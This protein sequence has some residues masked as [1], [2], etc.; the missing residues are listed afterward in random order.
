LIK[1]G[2]FISADYKAYEDLFHLKHVGSVFRYV[3]FKPQNKDD[4]FFQ[5]FVCERYSL[6]PREKWDKFDLAVPNREACLPS[7]VKYNK[8]NYQVDEKFWSVAEI[9]C[10]KHFAAAGN[11]YELEQNDDVFKLMDLSTSAGYPFNLLPGVRNKRKLL[12][13]RDMVECIYNYNE[14]VRVS[15][16][17]AFWAV[18]EKEEIRANKKL[19]VNRLRTFVGSAI[20][21]LYASM[22]MFWDMNEK[23][24][25]SAALQRN[26]SFVGA[27]KFRRGWDC[28]IK[29]LL[30]HPNAFALDETDYDCSLLERFLQSCE[31]IRGWFLVN[32]T[33]SQLIKIHNLYIEIIHSYMVLPFGDVIRKFLGNPSGSFNT[34]T[35]NVLVLYMLLAYAWQILTPE[36]FHTYECF[37]ANVEAALCGD[38]NTWTVSEKMV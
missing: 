11:S 1:P 15:E 34:I 35:D 2:N 17:P 21:F 32:P 20:D 23:L 6:L 37:H 19:I 3:P 38:D 30:K 8:N 10:A 7:I 25:Q 24:Y 29:R 28:Y 4:S 13:D 9:W 5:K 27:T 22:T 16:E 31:K 33:K 14:M 12:E 18:H 36:E 26:W